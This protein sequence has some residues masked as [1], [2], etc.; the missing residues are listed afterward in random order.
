MKD[1]TN[2]IDALQ[3]F[4]WKI[5]TEY[6]QAHDQE[7]KESLANSAKLLKAVVIGSL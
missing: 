3:A 7:E 2:L 5:R 4:I 1:N 6:D